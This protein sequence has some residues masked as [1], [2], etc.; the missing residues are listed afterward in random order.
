MASL[1]AQPPGVYVL[2][3][4]PPLAEVGAVGS[5]LPLPAGGLDAL[6]LGVP[7]PETAAVAVATACATSS[8][9]LSAARESP[10]PRLTA[11]PFDA[12]PDVDPKA[13]IGCVGGLP[14]TACVAAALDWA[15]ALP[16]E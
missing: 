8:S 2:R 12:L 14:P 6:A 13:L 11:A 5:G 3:S 7:F 16:R 1:P 4:L 15:V 10:T 9:A